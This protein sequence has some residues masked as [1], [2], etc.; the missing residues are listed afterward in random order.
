M[1][2]PVWLTITLVFLS[3]LCSIATN[4]TIDTPDYKTSSAEIGIIAAIIVLYTFVI[5]IIYY[6]VAWCLDM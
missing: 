1:W 3:F 6:V 5:P 2:Y 4:L